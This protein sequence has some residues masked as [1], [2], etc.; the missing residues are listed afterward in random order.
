MEGEATTLFP[1]LNA[2]LRR[3]GEITTAEGTPGKSGAL[4]VF[5]VLVPILLLSLALTG[6]TGANLIN[7]GSGWTVTATSDGVVYVVTRQGEVLALDVNESGTSRG[8]EQLNWRF[9][10]D[11]DDRLRGAFGKPAIGDELVYVGEKG[12]GKGKEGRLFALRKDRAS[13]T[14]RPDLGEWVRS[15]EGGIVGGAALSNDLVLV[16]SDDKTIYAFDKITG[17]LQWR[18]PTEGRIWSTPTV[19]DEVAYVGAM[20]RYVYAISLEPDLNLADRL[21]WR[22]KTG[23]AVLTNPLLLDDMVIV[24]SLDKKLYALKATTT[25]PGGQLAWSEP[26]EGDDW[27]WAGPIS[28]GENIY[29]ATMSGSLYAVDKN[30]IAI[31]GVPFKADS[32]IVS[33][34]VLLGE[35]LVV[36]TDGGRLFLLSALSGEKLE[37]FKDLDTGIKASL[38]AQG[39]TVVVGAQ[40]NVVHGYN[41]DQWVEKW[42][43]ETNK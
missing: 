33:T 16:A 27:F 29:A 31:W 18:F 21:L 2:D 7:W 17:R 28:N 10:L 42:S 4:R 30:G 24:G 38:S 32:P 8:S 39:S 14:L 3:S 23:G 36:A 11:G 43:F 9:A 1:N 34:P 25:N 15:I 19:R 5:L 13:T 12:D 20:D 6:C 37:I 41:V 40:N 26:F 35:N 22:Y